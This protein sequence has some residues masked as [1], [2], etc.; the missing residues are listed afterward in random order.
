[1]S[2]GDVSRYLQGGFEPAVRKAVAAHI[3]Y[4]NSCRE[5]LERVKTLRTAGRHM[6]ISNLTGS[7]D[8]DEP[9][10]DGGHVQEVV[11]A[12]YIDNGLTGGQ[13]NQVT[14]HIASCY[15]CYD[16]F[17]SLEKELAGTVPQALRTPVSVMEAMKKPIPSHSESLGVAHIGRRIVESLQNV[18]GLRWAQPAMAFAAGVL[19]MLT[20]L[21]SSRTVIPLPGVSPIQASFDD[22]IRSSVDGD[23]QEIDTRPVIMLPSGAGNLEFTW[24]GASKLTDS[25]YRVEIFDANGDQVLETIELTENKWVVDVSEFAPR[26]RYDILISRIG[27]AGGVSPVSQQSLLVAN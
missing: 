2:F 22:K 1:M 23:A 19:V 27:R 12:A 10:D 16:R 5:E 9:T 24:P 8:D 3:V 11:L 26:S 4:C 13:R 21:P 6:M 15:D 7:D 25:V 20:F 14:E 17:S 18:A